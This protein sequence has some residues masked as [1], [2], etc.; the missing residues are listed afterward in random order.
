M[1]T[2][3]LSLECD[4]LPAPA[5]S[6]GRVCYCLLF[7]SLA[8]AASQCQN[9]VLKAGPAYNL[10]GGDSSRTELPVTGD[11]RAGWRPVEHGSHSL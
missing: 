10:V 2:I 11:Y 9:I 6:P 3:T 4:T 8:G 7:P 1:S 5:Q